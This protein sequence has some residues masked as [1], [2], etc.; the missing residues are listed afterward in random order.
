M[1]RDFDHLEDAFVSATFDSGAPLRSGIQIKIPPAAPLVKAKSREDEFTRSSEEGVVPPQPE[2]LDQGR[3]RL[4]VRRIDAVVVGAEDE[5]T[6]HREKVDGWGSRPFPVEATG[7]EPA[8]PRPPVW[9][10]SQA[11]LRPGKSVMLAQG[12]PFG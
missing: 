10:A 3:E 6:R 8:T 4:E 2:S 11:A 1:S 5:R 7:F 9:C 12:T